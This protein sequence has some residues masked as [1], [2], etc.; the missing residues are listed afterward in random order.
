LKRFLVL[1]SLLLTACGG[2]P[3]AA[4][5]AG[6]VSGQLTVLAAASLTDAFKDEGKAFEKAHPGT[7]VQFSFGGSSGLATQI[8]QGAPADI[9]ASADQANLDKVRARVAGAQKVFAA[10][11]LQIAVAPGNPKRIG[12]LADLARPGL[13]VVL[14]A[15]QVPCGTYALEAFKKAGVAVTPRSQET[16]VRAVLTKIA[17]GEA[18]AGIVY[19]TDVKSGGGSVQGVDIPDVQNVVAGYPVAVLE[20]A[21]NPRAAQAFTDFLVSPGG[22]AILT[23][24]GFQRP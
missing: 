14:C 18:D 13:V 1:A 21:P 22:Q 24:Y 15:P 12:S 8:Q 11:R 5:T 23:R 4:P 9:F 16:D 17:T 3:A 6:P 10:N 2:S 20:G 7:N 19:A